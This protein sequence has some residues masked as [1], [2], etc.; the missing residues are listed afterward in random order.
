MPLKK[1]LT[2][3]MPYYK[4]IKYFKKAYTS[5]VNQTYKNFNIILVYDDE[6][7]E[8]LIKIK[9]IIKIKNFKLIINKKNIGV[10]PSRN[11]AIN[12]VKTKYIA[13]LDCDDYWEKNK[14][15]Y[16]LNFMKK[17][18]LKFSHTSYNILNADRLNSF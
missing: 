5:V 11:K 14:V 18:K 7:K 2:I 9:R 17:N 12:F 10:G 15:K 8:D 3:I 4:K 1:D 16:Q 6:L 13:F